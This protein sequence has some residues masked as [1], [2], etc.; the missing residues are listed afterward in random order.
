MTHVMTQMEQNRD[1]VLG[2]PIRMQRV[3]SPG[4]KKNMLL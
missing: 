3:L 1:T 4:G 2:N